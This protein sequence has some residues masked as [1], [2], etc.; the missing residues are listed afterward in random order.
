TLRDL[1]TNYKE[2]FG[3]FKEG[4][5]KIILHS[6]IFNGLE[7]DTNWKELVPFESPHPSLNSYET[8][9]I[10]NHFLYR[11]K[12]IILLGNYLVSHQSKQLIF[13]IEV[14]ST[15]CEEVLVK[16]QYL[17]SYGNILQSDLDTLNSTLYEY[18]SV[19]KGTFIPRPWLLN[20][21]NYKKLSNKSKK[22]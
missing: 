6:Q 4:N 22:N 8:F 21:Y 16:K 13:A 10:G 20:Y 17:I 18:F 12:L 9:R 1:L 19:K 2:I 11:N 7:L 14:N 3:I 15:L 5:D